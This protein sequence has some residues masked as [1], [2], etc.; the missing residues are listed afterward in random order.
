MMFLYG[1]LFG[2]ALD[3]AYTR[4]WLKLAYEWAKAKATEKKPAPL[5]LLDA[6]ALSRED[7]QAGDLWVKFRGFAKGAA[8]AIL[9]VGGL[10][11]AIAYGVNYSKPI[12][13]D[14]KVAPAVQVAPPAAAIAPAKQPPKKATKPAVEP[15]PTAANVPLVVLPVSQPEPLTDFDKRVLN[16]ERKMP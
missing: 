11:A 3:Q 8:W 13:I 14:E 4:G 15:V 9:L 6:G 1:L 10:I 12:N 5:P 7:W 2:V 16:F